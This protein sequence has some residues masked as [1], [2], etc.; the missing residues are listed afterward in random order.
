FALEEAARN[1][2]GGGELFL[3]VDGQRE[4]VLPFLDRLGRRD[5]AQDHRVTELR[6]NGAIGLT[7]HAARFQSEGLAAPLDFYLVDIE[8]A[9]FLATGRPMRPGP[10]CCGQYR[11]PVGPRWSLPGVHRIAGA[12]YANGPARG[13]VPFTCEGRASR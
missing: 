5:G 12:R 8:H 6:Q 2:S 11:P 9:V 1:A 10:L 7:G 3:I 13:A 4:E